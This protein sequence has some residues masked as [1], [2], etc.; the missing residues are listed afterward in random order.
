MTC[1]QFLEELDK[2]LGNMRKQQKDE[3]L[4]DFSDHIR[5]A[6]IEGKSDS[7]ILEALGDPVAIASQFLQDSKGKSDNFSESRSNGPDPRKS[8]E[9]RSSDG[10]ISISRSFD[11]SISAIKA[12]FKRCNMVFESGS[13][14]GIQVSIVGK[15]KGPIKFLES[16]TSLSVLEDTP[17]NP[18]SFMLWGKISLDVKITVPQGWAGSFVGHVNTGSASASGAKAKSVSLKVEVGDLSAKSCAVDELALTNNV[19]NIEIDRCAFGECEA[20]LS[21][22]NLKASDCKGLL[23]ATNQTGDV[24]IKRHVGNI[25]AF[26][27]IG[28]VHATDIAGAAAIQ[29]S[30]GDIHVKAERLEATIKTSIGEIDAE[31]GEAA[32]LKVETNTGDIHARISRLTGDCRISSGIGEVKLE[33]D[34]VQGSISI[35]TGSGDI[36]AYLPRDAQLKIRAES[37]MGNIKN[38]FISNPD[39]ACS[40]SANTRMGNIAIK[41]R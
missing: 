40:I 3:I 15:T 31:A 7:E 16:E 29:T 35:K 21:V 37:G 11:A 41:K 32:D 34:F 30:T 6:R 19:G 4:E 10:W 2:A 1:E 13:R 25:S 14:S 23:K 9:E 39:A 26:N 12:D 33:T 8:H 27:S 36:K 18:L 17:F 5:L 28:E 38:E 24:T 22:G 20:K